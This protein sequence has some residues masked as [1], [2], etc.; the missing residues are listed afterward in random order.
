MPVSTA[1]KSSENKNPYNLSGFIIF[2]FSLFFSLGFFI[3]VVY[4]HPPI[5]LQEISEEE[6]SGDGPTL[7]EKVEQYETPWIEVDFMATYG[8]KNL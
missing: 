7:T 8:Q 2:L 1:N 3:Y 5:D 4:I 6:L